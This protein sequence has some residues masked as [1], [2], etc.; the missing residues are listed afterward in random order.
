MNRKI[1]LFFSI[2]LLALVQGCSDDRQ[3]ST[4]SVVDR[5]VIPSYVVPQH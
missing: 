1:L 5:D 2:I 3:D 4:G